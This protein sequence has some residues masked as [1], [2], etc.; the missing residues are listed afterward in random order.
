MPSKRVSLLGTRFQFISC[1]SLWRRAWLW[2]DRPW[3]CSTERAVCA[4]WRGSLCLT[5]TSS[6]CLGAACLGCSIRCGSVRLVSGRGVSSLG[7]IVLGFSC[8]CDCALCWS[9]LRG[10]DSRVWYCLCC[11]SLDG[12]GF[13][14]T[15]LDCMSLRSLWVGVC[16]IVADRRSFNSACVFW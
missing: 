12:I 5:L 16:T 10:C 13:D 9:T 15:G 6:R 3:L 1:Y 4:F 14:C 11:G 8:L 7:V 2:V